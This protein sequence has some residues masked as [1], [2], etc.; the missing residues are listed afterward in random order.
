MEITT[1]RVKQYS[2]K[3]IFVVCVE[4]IPFCTVRGKNAL[5]RIIQRLNGI[6]VQ[7][8]D[9]RIEFECDKLIKELRSLK[10]YD[11]ETFIISQTL[12]KE[13]RAD[14]RKKVLEKLRLLMKERAD[15]CSD[16]PNMFDKGYYKAYEHMCEEI[17]QLKK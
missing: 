2:S 14:E 11:G 6:D 8:E 17:A 16:I 1:Y 10:T 4:G 9:K 13:V 12:E 15:D 5:N 3:M 7:F